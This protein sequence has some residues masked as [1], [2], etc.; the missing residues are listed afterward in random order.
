M[1]DPVVVVA[2]WTTTEAALDEVLGHVAALL[3]ASLAEPGCVGYEAFQSL[4]DPTTVL[5][6]EHYVDDGALD[7]HVSSAHYQDVV[8]RRVRPLLTDR[9]VEFLRPR[10]QT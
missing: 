1:S 4:T 6:V 10:E 7:A 8:L 9:R 3:P 5:L 2:Q